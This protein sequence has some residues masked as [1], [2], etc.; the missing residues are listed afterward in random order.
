MVCV[1]VSAFVSFMWVIPP[2]LMA[3][4]CVQRPALS[5]SLLSH[6]CTQ[7]N[8]RTQRGRFFGVPHPNTPHNTP[9]TASVA[10][11]FQGESWSVKFQQV[12]LRSQTLPSFFWNSS[13]FVYF[14]PFPTL[15]MDD[16][17]LPFPLNLLYVIFLTGFSCL[18][19]GQLFFFCLYE[20]EMKASAGLQSTERC[21]KE[22]PQKVSICTLHQNQKHHTDLSV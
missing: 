9:A 21:C 6:S 7:T 15:T 16:Y 3:P 17:F 11:V 8:A 14:N 4:R 22:K 2:C 13:F 5:C 20:L 1:C 19:H 12:F 18:P 10:P